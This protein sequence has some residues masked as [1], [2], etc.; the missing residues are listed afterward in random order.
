M[1][2]PR[3]AYLF[4]GQG[5][6][7][8][9]MGQALA[10]AYPAAREV[11]ERADAALGRPL[12]RL[13]F[14]GSAEDLALTENTQPSVLAVDVA[15]LRTL[16]THGLRP[17]AAAGHSLGE[18]AALVIAGV[19]GFED[20]LRAVCVRASL[21]QEAGEQ[22]PGTM[23]AIIGLS[24]EAVR[25][26]CEAASTEEDRV[27]PANFNAPGQVVVSGTIPAVHRAM[28]Q[29]KEAGAKLA[30]KLSVSGAFHS[31]L[32]DSVGR[33]ME[34]AL[35][36][37]AFSPAQIPIVDNVTADVVRD[38]DKIRDL[39]IQQLTHPVLW[40]ASM[41]K[42]VAMGIGTVIEVGPGKV[43]QGLMRRIDRSVRT[44]GADRAEEVRNTV[45]NSG[46][47]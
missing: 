27:C 22:H 32:M 10:E 11:F 9:G 15:A 44:L 16:E 34:E 37:I 14:E 8:P 38:P 45:E 2:A 25:T 12:S 42:L 7:N 20:A 6:Q 39:L 23:A 5:S 3:F 18:Y 40:V 13:C 47:S 24:D 19:L 46:S 31:P 33:K 30:V 28:E 29:A 17:V 36:G 1:T 35:S 41:Q 4:P 43:L 26:I 21:M